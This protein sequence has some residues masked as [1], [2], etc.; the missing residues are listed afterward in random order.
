[1][2]SQQR[3]IKSMSHYH[4][5]EDTRNLILTYIKSVSRRHSIENTKI[6]ILRTEFILRGCVVIL[7]LKIRDA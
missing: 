4:S 6:L 7:Q 1:M 2:Y 3:Y 5:I